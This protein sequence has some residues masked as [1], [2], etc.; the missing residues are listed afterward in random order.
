[1]SHT[2]EVLDRLRGKIA[3]PATTLEE[4]RERR[5]TTL[6]AARAFKGV[7]RVYNAG[8]IAHGTANADT[9]ADC[10]IVLD[11]RVW[12]ELGPDGENAGPAG[13]VEDVRKLVRE[14]VKSDHPDLKT[15]LSKR[16]IVLRF[17]AELGN[18]SDPSVDLIVALQR[19][20]GGLWIPNLHGSGS[21]DAAHPVRHTELL[22]ADPKSLRV[23]RARIIRLAKCWNVQYSEPGM[24][25]FNIEALA[26]ACITE[27]M[28]LAT[29]LAEF[30]AFASKDVAKHNTPDPADVSKPIK[31]K[32]ERQVIV[33]RL[34]KA[35]DLLLT[36]LDNDDDEVA[37]ETALADLFWK[38]L[39]P[40]AGA[41]SKAAM[42][43]SLRTGNSGV[44]M[45]AGLT[46]GG[47]G[48]EV[49][50]TRAFGGAER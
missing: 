20:S 40:P 12:K 23:T 27:G 25:S 34:E 24:C 22:T 31:L 15:W 50:T 14:T 17:R 29:G 36:A 21:W 7:V 18:G 38:H 26:L 13:V 1:M 37:V 6:D 19:T 48:A 30:F 39:K 2:A 9:D 49:K 44:R 16:A 10:G 47:A 46:L 3:P 45:G 28:G 35:A 41:A 32:V 4:V 33:A 8:S 11:R 5:K 42:A 43:R